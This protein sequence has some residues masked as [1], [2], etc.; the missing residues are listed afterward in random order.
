MLILV[1]SAISLVMMPF[2]SKFGPT[3]C[4]VYNTVDL[5]CRCNDF[6]LLLEMDRILRPEGW[7]IFRDRVTT[8]G[9]VEEILQSLHWK[10]V[11]S[12]TVENEQL[13]VAQK[14]FWR[15]EGASR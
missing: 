3:C 4:S 12:Y 11:L 8:L 2:C 9:K 13:L 5:L 15:P 6:N 10:V 14:T 1:A 7:A